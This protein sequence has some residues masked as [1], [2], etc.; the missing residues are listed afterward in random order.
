MAQPRTL[1]QA[2]EAAADRGTGQLVFHASGAKPLRLPFGELRQDALVGAAHLLRLGVHPG[3][4]VGILGPNSAE[5]ARWAVS[6]WRLGGVL[7]PLGFPLRVRD[8]S[9]VQEQL[10]ALIRAAQCTLVLAAPSLAFAVPHGIGREWGWQPASP[11]EAASLGLPVPEDPEAHA[12]AQFTSGGTAF[13]KGAV[14][15]NRAILSNF[16]SVRI[17]LRTLGEDERFLGWLPFF[18]DNGLFGYLVRP[19]VSGGHADLLPTEGFAQ[20]PREWLRMATNERSTLTSGPPSAWAVTLRAART[21]PEGLDLSSLRIAVLSAETIDPELVGRLRSE[22]VRFGLRPD[23]LLAGYGLA[24][25]TLGVT[26]GEPGGGIRIDEVDLDVLASSGR[27]VPG[28]GSRMKRIVSC[29]RP[30]PGTS[31][32]VVQDEEV[33]EDR[34]VGEIEVRT[35]S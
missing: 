20:D 23:S 5:W 34:R 32:R 31:V 13:P 7:V 26:V 15:T 18:H 25:A 17:A 14:L 10:G 30:I 8:K 3:D 16:E 11:G 28:I 24:E 19:L 35:P 9:A 33:L 12:V 22:M 4:R 21:R 6:I 1:A 29:G 27:A 2:L